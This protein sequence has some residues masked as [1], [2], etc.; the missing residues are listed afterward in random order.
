MSA[1]FNVDYARRLGAER[2]AAAAASR[3]AAEAKRATRG[4]AVPARSGVRALRRR[5]GWLLVEL[6]LRLAVA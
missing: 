1:H 3:A 5:S 2:C 4:E 6:G